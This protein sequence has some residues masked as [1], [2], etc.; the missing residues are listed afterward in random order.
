MRG[1]LARREI[2]LRGFAAS[3]LKASSWSVWD[4]GDPLPALFDLAKNVGKLGSA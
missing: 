3:L 1:M 4:P 2:T